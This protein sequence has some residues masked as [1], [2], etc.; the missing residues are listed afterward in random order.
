MVNCMK[1]MK[2]I[3]TRYG[4][5]IKVLGGQYLCLVGG[6][7][8]FLISRSH[9]RATVQKNSEFAQNLENCLRELEIYAFTLSFCFF[10]NYSHI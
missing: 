2:Y 9:G 8:E 4:A 7:A 5:A 10:L 1:Y 6:R 3:N